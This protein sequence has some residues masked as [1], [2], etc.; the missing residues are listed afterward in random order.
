MPSC[1]CSAD[2]ALMS[3]PVSL[4]PSLLPTGNMLKHIQGKSLTDWYI[5]HIWEA[6]ELHPCNLENWLWT[7]MG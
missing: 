6:N 2:S 3:N 1:L 7:Q 5:T 4:S